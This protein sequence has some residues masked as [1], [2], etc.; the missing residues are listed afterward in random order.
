MVGRK[1]IIVSREYIMSKDRE[2]SYNVMDVIIIE[3]CVV[4]V[5]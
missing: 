1:R 3:F 5:K 4:G 2:V